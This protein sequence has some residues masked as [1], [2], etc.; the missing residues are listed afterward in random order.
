MTGRDVI[1]NEH[2]FGQI[3]NGVQKDLSVFEARATSALMGRNTTTLHSNG[4]II[5]WLWSGEWNYTTSTI[6]IIT[7][8]MFGTLYYVYIMHSRHSL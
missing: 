5:F 4:D 2:L 7:T 1:E 6:I 3:Q 8:S